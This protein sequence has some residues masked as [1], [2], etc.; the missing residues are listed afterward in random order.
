MYLVL[1]EC[2]YEGESYLPCNITMQLSTATFKLLYSVSMI[3]HYIFTGISVVLLK[4]DS[5]F[6]FFIL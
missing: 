5:A 2:V 4:M 6:F 1:E 3:C